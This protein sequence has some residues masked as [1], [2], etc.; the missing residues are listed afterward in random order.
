[1]DDINIHTHGGGERYSRE[2]RVLV[3]VPVRLLNISTDVEN[4]TQAKKYIQIK[5]M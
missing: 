2:E 5:Q 4:R 3:K 1:M